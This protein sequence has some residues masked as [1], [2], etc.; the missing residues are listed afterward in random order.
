MAQPARYLFD[1]DFSAPPEPE[2]EEVVEDIIEEEEPPE[3]TITVAEHEQLIETIRQQAYEQGLEEGRQEREQS[4]TEKNNELQ[5]TILDEIAMIYTEVGVLMARLEKDA[6]TLA[7]RFASRFAQ[8]LVDQEPKAE[9]QALL[10]QILAPLRKS[11]HLTIRVHSDLAQD[12]KASTKKQMKEL[13]FKGNLMVRGDDMIAPGDCEVEWNDGG[14]GR[15]MRDAIQH[16]ETLLEQH[17]AT[18][19]EEEIPEE[20]DT[21]AEDEKEEQTDT[22][23]PTDQTDN[24]ADPSGE[25]SEHSETNDLSPDSPDQQ[26]QNNA[27]PHDD[28]QQ[29]TQPDQAQGEPL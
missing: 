23:A 18:V 28:S 29:R 17:F 8:K 15:N 14:I 16:A 7:F 27:A 25:P 20:E 13:G 5:K 4:A 12:I 2:I 19:P 10:N 9:I 24:T 11:P 21:K 3:P 1:L 26:Q 22:E 6:S